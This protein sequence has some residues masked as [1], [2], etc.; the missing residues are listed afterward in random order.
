VLADLEERTEELRELMQSAAF[1]E[2][3]EEIVASS[4]GQDTLGETDGG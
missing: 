4:L 1:R 3:V 2:R